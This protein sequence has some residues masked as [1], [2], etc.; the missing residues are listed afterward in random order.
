MQAGSM[1]HSCLLRRHVSERE[2]L[3]ALKQGTLNA[4]KSNMRCASVSGSPK[5][6]V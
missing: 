1:E 5:Q 2:V 4:R 6:L 3:A